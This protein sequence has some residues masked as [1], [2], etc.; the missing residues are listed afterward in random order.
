MLDFTLQGDTYILKDGSYQL[1]LLDSL[2]SKIVQESILNVNQHWKNWYDSN[3]KLKQA[4][5]KFLDS[6]NELE[7]MQYIYQDLEKLYPQ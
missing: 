5:D 7:E 1:N 2:D 3:F 4:K 6:K